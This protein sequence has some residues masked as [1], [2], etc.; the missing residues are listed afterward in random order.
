MEKEDNNNEIL[1]LIKMVPLSERRRWVRLES[2]CSECDQEFDCCCKL[3]RHMKKQHKKIELKQMDAL[4]PF[5]LEIFDS[6][7]CVLMHIFMV[8]EEKRTHALEALKERGHVDQYYTFITVSN[9][10]PKC[11]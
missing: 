1:K 10:C 8:H 5:C 4:C 3:E 11:K 9:G 2:T 7:C 6:R